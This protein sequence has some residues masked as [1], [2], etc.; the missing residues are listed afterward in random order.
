M[1]SNWRDFTYIIT[2]NISNTIAAPPKTSMEPARSARQLVEKQA[3]VS[4][5]TRWRRGVM[6]LNRWADML[7]ENKKHE[8]SGAQTL[9][10]NRSNILQ[11]KLS[12]AFSIKIKLRSY[13]LNTASS[14]QLEASHLCSHFVPEPGRANTKQVFSRQHLHLLRWVSVQQFS[15]FLDWALL[16][17]CNCLLLS[18]YVPSLL[19]HAQHVHAPC[20]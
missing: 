16:L 13:S 20:Q 12:L 9:K 11:G 7:R 2:W 15:N 10:A 8:I 17:F 19:S 5:V 6:F 14:W 1:Q 4:D 18:C 3:D